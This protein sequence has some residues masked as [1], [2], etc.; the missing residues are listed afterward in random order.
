ML[1]QIEHRGTLGTNIVCNSEV[2]YAMRPLR[3]HANASIP[4]FSL[5]RQSIG[6]HRH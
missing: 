3:R 6:M 5:W 4:Y 2:Q 1:I